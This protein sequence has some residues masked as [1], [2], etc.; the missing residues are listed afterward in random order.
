MR[1]LLSRSDYEFDVVGDAQIR[2]LLQVARA[3]GL[4]ALQPTADGIAKLDLQIAGSWSAF[5]PALA[6]GSAQLQSVHAEIRG[7]NAPL[8]I[9]SASLLLQPDKITASKVTASLATSNWRG[10]FELPRQC[11]V[12]RPCPVL[13]D[14][15]A[16]AISTDALSELFDPHPRNRPWYRFLSAAPE[17]R[18]PYLLTLAADGRLVADRVALHKLVASRVSA[19]V[20][21]RNG[22]LQLNDVQGDVLGGRHLGFWKADFRA[23]PPAY[24]GSGTLER[25]AL[26]QLAQSMHDGWITGI[27]TATYQVAADGLTAGELMSSASAAGEV[28]SLRGHAAAYRAVGR[29]GAP[30]HALLHRTAPAARCQVGDSGGQTGRSDGVY[31]VSGTASLGRV[32]NLNLDARRSSQPQ[33]HWSAHR[34]ARHRGEHAGNPGGFETM[35][36]GLTVLMLAVVCCAS[37]APS[38]RGDAQPMAV[39]SMVRKLRRI[40][41]VGSSPHPPAHPHGI[42]RRGNQCLLC[43]GES[44]SPRGGRIR[45]ISEQAEWCKATTRVD[46]ERIKAGAELVQHRCSRF[47]GA[48]MMWTWWLTPRPPAG[49]DRWRSIRCRWTVSRYPGLFCSCLSR[50]T[51]SRS[52]QTWVW[53]QVF[54]CRTGSTKRRSVFMS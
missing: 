13:F 14:L 15:H 6:L 3:L 45:P 53:I 4:S 36:S 47:F 44:R 41:S 5:T 40:E 43:R 35:K 2:R 22:E 8:E 28:R 54:L 50:T 24:N 29:R 38:R 11:G 46:F 7:L 48:S 34:A 12:P 33:H 19:N 49:W 27:G 31:Q 10:S 37:Q 23:K 21:L 51:F 1:A 25:I 42:E 20:E 30:S 39:A 18:N 9:A 16:D 17:S 52:I 26:G 32:L